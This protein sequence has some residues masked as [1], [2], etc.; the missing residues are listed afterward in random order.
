MGR[1]RVLQVGRS[2]S[3]RVGA[4]HGGSQIGC[5][6][7]RG[8]LAGRAVAI[9]AAQVWEVSSQESVAAATQVAPSQCRSVGGLSVEVS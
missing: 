4:D 9:D 7:G 2:G 3:R 1:V 5:G 6:K 8:L